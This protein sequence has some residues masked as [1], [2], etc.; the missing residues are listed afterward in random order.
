[1]VTALPLM[2]TSKD[3][4]G[5]TVAQLLAFR[6]GGGGGSAAAGKRKMNI[7]IAKQTNRLGSTNIKLLRQI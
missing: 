3:F 5:Y 4:R 2:V 6:E 1:M 7:L